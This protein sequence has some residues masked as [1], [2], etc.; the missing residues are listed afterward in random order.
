MTFELVR[1]DIQIERILM[2]DARNHFRCICT[3]AIPYFV[4]PQSK[5]QDQQAWRKAFV[6]KFHFLPQRHQVRSRRS[7]LSGVIF[8]WTPVLSLVVFC[9][10]AERFWDAIICYF[11]FILTQLD[12]AECAHSKYLK[13]KSSVY[14]RNRYWS[15]WLQ[16]FTFEL[17]YNGPREFCNKRAA[18]F[19][20]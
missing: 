20:Y 12:N 11:Q 4:K 14:S 18:H 17:F 6:Q 8:V 3:S 2:K 10:H 15:I 5:W 1:E 16:T 7:V 13:F 19:E 9:C